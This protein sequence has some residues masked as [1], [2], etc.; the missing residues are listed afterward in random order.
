MH[1]QGHLMPPVASLVVQLVG[2][3]IAIESG[4]KLFQL[5]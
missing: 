5:I 2:D 3:I 4:A 1:V